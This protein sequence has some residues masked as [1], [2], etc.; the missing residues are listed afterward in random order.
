MLRCPGSTRQGAGWGDGGRDGSA[1]ASPA[2]RRR[3]RAGL[4][5]AGPRDI[6]GSWACRA[7]A[8]W[9]ISPCEAPRL[10]PQRQKRGW[11]WAAV[12]PVPP[13]CACAIP[14]RSHGA[15]EPP[16]YRVALGLPAL[17]P[18]KCTG[19]GLTSAGAAPGASP[20]VCCFPQNCWRLLP[21]CAAGG[22]SDLG[23]A[24]IHVGY[25]NLAHC[26]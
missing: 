5:G 15:G 19:V 3:P 6:S 26:S 21:S 1:P 24:H 2:G 13:G 23:R 4:A 25:R 8:T 17:L 10:F 22:S 9:F 14:T 7:L 12:P 11:R 20:S 16:L 18:T